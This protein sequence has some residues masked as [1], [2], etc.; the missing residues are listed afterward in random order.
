[1]ALTQN[2]W[3]MAPLDPIVPLA[4]RIDIREKYCYTLKYTPMYLSTMAPFHA[5]IKPSKK[6]SV[7]QEHTIVYIIDTV[8]C[9][10]LKTKCDFQCCRTLLNCLGHN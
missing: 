8:Q 5:L 7:I 1:M 9:T 3:S 2:R 4:L 10:V 6:G